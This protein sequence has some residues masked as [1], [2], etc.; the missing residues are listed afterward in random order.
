MEL[1]AREE[2]LTVVEYHDLYE[3]ITKHFAFEREQHS[4]DRWGNQYHKELGIYLKEFEFVAIEEANND[5][6]YT[7]KITGNLYD[8]D[9]PEMEEMLVRKEFDNFSTRRILDWLASKGIIPKGT[10]LIKVSW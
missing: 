1:K 10:Y 8:W 4:S 3:F 9:K 2:T 7:Y 6:S 5:S